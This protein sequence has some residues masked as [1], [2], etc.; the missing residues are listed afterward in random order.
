MVALKQRAHWLIPLAASFTA[1]A[2]VLGATWWIS[3]EL[4]DQMSRARKITVIKFQLTDFVIAL[5]NATIGER[6]FLLTGE[7]PYLEP[8]ERAKADLEPALDRLIQSASGEPKLTPLLSRLRII[9]EEKLA[10]LQTSIDLKK[11]GQD[12]DVLSVLGEGRGK[13]LLDEATRIANEVKDYV[14]DALEKCSA[15]IVAKTGWIEIGQF[16]A[17]LLVFT[18]AGFAYRLN[19]R[20]LRDLVSARDNLVLANKKLVA[21]SAE[22]VR[23]SAQLRQ[24]Q[25]MEAIGQLTGGIAHDFNNMLAVIVGSLSLF[26]RRVDRGDMQASLGLIDDALGGANRA[27]TLTARLLA[28]S[29][30]QPLAPVVLDPNKLIAGMSSL[31]SRTLG[32]NIQV[33]ILFAGAIW[34]TFVDANQLENALLNLCINSRDAMSE[35]GQLTI[36]TS[37]AEL[38][39]PYVAE[40]EDV[41]AGQYVLVAVTDT[42]SGMSPE[43]VAKAFE[44]F[45]TTKTSAEGTGLG[46]SQVFGFV[47]QSGGHV[48]IYSELGQ[49]TTIKLYLPRYLEK[50]EKLQNSDVVAPSPPQGRPSETILVVEDEERVRRLNA[51]ALRELGYTVIHVGNA[52][53]A[54]R[55]LESDRSINLLLTDVVLPE[56]DGRKLADEALRCDPE[57]KI[58]LT[59]GF[60]RNAIVHK[61]PLDPGIH[62]ITKPFNLMEL[63]TKVRQVLDEDRKG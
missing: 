42:G 6:G 59:T 33:E 49:G 8:F 60:T 3:I 16:T 30:Q 28:F 44:P 48:K 40:N 43:V 55:V 35:G 52:T 25:K 19:K 54:M 26:K 58:I 12:D 21:E 32:Q 9:T 23:V 36:E 38:D 24:S 13:A 63:A 61:G 37:N 2:T 29:R 62:L 31:L 46:L 22:R 51:Q 14:L 50:G 57:L 18:S 4:A 56:I 15:S 5:Q 10:L 11:A 47:K 34:R 45:F 39:D 27:A 41:V 20:Q 53:A 7:D 1:L 17:A